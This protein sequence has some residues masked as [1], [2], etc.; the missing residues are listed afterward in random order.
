MAFKRF[1]ELGAEW[2]VEP[3]YKDVRGFEAFDSQG[4]DI[5]KVDDLLVNTDNN[6]INYALVG[7]DGIAQRFGGKD[8][9]VPL[10]KM[11]IDQEDRS[12]HLD[13][14][15][16]RLMQFPDYN[17]IE[18]PD[19]MS[20]VEDFWGP[21]TYMRPIEGRE[22]LGRPITIP[23][24]EERARVQKEMERTG[25][26]EVTMKEEVAREP[27]TEEVKGERVEVER[28][29]IKEQPLPE[30][31]REH[32]EEQPREMQPGE[33][34]SVPVTEERIRVTKEPVVVE[35]IRLRRV[36]TERRVTMEE[37]IHKERPEVKKKGEEP[38]A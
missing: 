22:R 30:Y 35:E 31:E 8:I 16:D 38:A 6:T 18:D 9:I 4:K 2:E 29:K 20:K 12:I 37:E 34:I 27:I 11:D 33:T 17:T 23:V 24:V 10:R 25:E 28:E 1:S 21:G 5:G 19:L 36:P 26:V 13:V 14:S 15:Q 7:G 3:E 32:A